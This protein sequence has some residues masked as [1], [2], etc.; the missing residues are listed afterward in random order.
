MT[1]RFSV[2]RWAAWAPGL[3]DHSVWRAWLREPCAISQQEE[4]PLVE[5]PAMIRRRVERLG[6]VALQATYWGQGDC[7][8]CPIVFASR[9]GDIGRSIQLLRQ[10]ATGEPLSPAAFSTSVHNAIGALYSIANAHTG[11]YTAIAAGEET[12]EAAFVE[13]LGQLADG[14]SE[15]LLVYYDEP[16]PVPYDV[17]QDGVDLRFEFVRA[18]AY[19]IRLVET[20]GY[21]LLSGP[22]I[23]DKNHDHD[24]K[25]LPPDVAVL[26]FLVSD[27]ERQYVHTVGARR[28]EWS[29]HA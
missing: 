29:H 2:E 6:R 9:R 18:M 3:S 10:L 19:R 23:V 5:M 7:V 25:A 1:V 14:A 8:Q 17:F 15:V 4:P 27:T 21:S 13:A 12:I 24:A 20:G 28:W 26:N 11:S 22:V 16:L